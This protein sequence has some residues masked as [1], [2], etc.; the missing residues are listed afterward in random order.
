[1]PDDNHGQEPASGVP[2]NGRSSHADS[3]ASGPG[4]V[5]GPQETD[6]RII[7]SS[8][9]F[10]YHYSHRTRS[11]VI[12]SVLSALACLIF[13]ALPAI[14]ASVI[15]ADSPITRLLSFIPILIGIPYTFF[16]IYRLFIQGSSES[17]ES[18]GPQKVDLILNLKGEG[19]ELAGWAGGLAV[20]GTVISILIEF[21]H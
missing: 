5:E 4:A 20:I 3:Q 2:A 19:K 1:M 15:G 6:I 12:L 10:T 21:L 16:V 13:V 8:K 17:K 18:G 14:I 9:D 11:R 7:L